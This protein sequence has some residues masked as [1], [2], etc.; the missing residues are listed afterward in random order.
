MAEFTTA[1]HV[2]VYGAA[3]QSMVNNPE[4]PVGREMKRRADAVTAL[5]KVFC[6]VESWESATRRRR[7]PGR[8]RDS[9]KPT[10][11]HGQGYVGIGY[12]VGSE[13]V[14]AR[15]IE[16]NHRVGGY[17]RKGLAAAGGTLVPGGLTP[18]VLP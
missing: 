1:S 11:V 14:Y 16:F 2:T 6:P 9:I 8:L 3:L 7:R 15:R 13:L 4:G 10:R 5:A 12:L 17:L 18:G